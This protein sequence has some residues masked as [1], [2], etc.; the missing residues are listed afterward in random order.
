MLGG[1]CVG[2]CVYPVRDIE[3]LLF[4]SSSFWFRRLK[5][6]PGC[7]RVSDA[8]SVSAEG[9]NSLE[10]S[11]LCNHTVTQEGGERWLGNSVATVQV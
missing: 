1:G 10:K 4:S 6:D 3:F 9:R 5:L 2:D 11:G 7:V 8:Q